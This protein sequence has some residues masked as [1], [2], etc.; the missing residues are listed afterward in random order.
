VFPQSQEQLVAQ[1]SGDKSKYVDMLLFQSSAE[2]LFDEA[3]QL[4]WLTSDGIYSTI[5][6]PQLDALAKTA[7]T[8]LDTS[9]RQQA[10]DQ[11]NNL[12]CQKVYNVYLYYPP[13]I[14]GLSKH[15]DW[16]PRADG[17]VLAQDIKQAS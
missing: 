8:S 5:N 9:T 2:V 14:Y 6:D 10:Y 15:I 12:A 11:L 3:Q 1:F 17:L 7:T 16:T 4:Q 13:A